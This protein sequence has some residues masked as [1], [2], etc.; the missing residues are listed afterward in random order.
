M[1]SIEILTKNRKELVQ[2]LKNKTDLVTLFSDIYA[3]TGHFVYELLQ[4]AEDQK[5]TK[6]TIKLLKRFLN[7]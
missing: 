4:N 6:V 2:T 7:S 3:E 5:A 1:K